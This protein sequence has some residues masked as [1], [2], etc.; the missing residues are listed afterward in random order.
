VIIIFPK[1][2]KKF[3]T[4]TFYLYTKRTKEIMALLGKLVVVQIVR[5]SSALR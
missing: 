2:R 1:L 5:K 4:N 3:Y